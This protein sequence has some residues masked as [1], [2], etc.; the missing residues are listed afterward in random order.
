VLEEGTPWANK[1]ELYIGLIKEAVRKDMKESNCPFVL[2]D[3]CIER[4]ACTN[5]LTAKDI[6][7]LHGRNAHT[8]STKNEDSIDANRRLLNQRPAYKKI[9]HSEV[10]LQ[11]LGDSISTGKVTQHALGPDGRTA[12]SYDDNPM[13]NSIIYEVEFPDGQVKEYTVNV[14]VENMLTQ[15]DSDGYSTTILKAIIDYQKGEALAVP[16]ADKYVYISS[17]QKRL[18]KTTV[19]CSLLIQWADE[20]EAWVPLKDLKESHPCEAAE[21]AKA[22]GIA[23]K[24]AF[25]CWIP[26]SLRKRDIILSKIKVRIRKTIDTYGIKAPTS[27]EHAFAIDKKNGNTLWCDA[28]AKEMTETGIAFEVLDEGIQAPKGWSKVTGHLVWDVKMDFTRKARWVIDGHKTDDPTGSTYPGVVS[29][30][31]V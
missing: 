1:A 3:Y 16:K 20:S 28:L 31:S 17:R 27:M 4:R 9:M 6:F 11:E 7:K 8:A 10:A 24:P 21:F 29:R 12:G 30:E 18:Q 25:A 14:I 22:Q 23:D 15:V 5:N 2:W 26:Y 13:L 19:G